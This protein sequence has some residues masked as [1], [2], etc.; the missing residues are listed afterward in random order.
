MM[1]EAGTLKLQY[2][3]VPTYLA[4]TRCGQAVPGESVHVS[5][6][7]GASK[8]ST[9]LLTGKVACK[10]HYKEAY[11]SSSPLLR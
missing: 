11:L 7:C 4:D 10:P 6:I 8:Q 3:T 9:L 5:H 1:T 2:A